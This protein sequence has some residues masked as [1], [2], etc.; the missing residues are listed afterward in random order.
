MFQWLRVCRH[1]FVG[2]II[3]ILW[4]YG[5][6]LCGPLRTLL[7]YE[8]STVVV[9]AIMTA[10]FTHGSTPARVRQSHSCCQISWLSCGMMGSS[11]YRASI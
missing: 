1:A 7:L 3:N 9:I 4:L 6:T 5:L 11:N 2:C 10:L 8:H